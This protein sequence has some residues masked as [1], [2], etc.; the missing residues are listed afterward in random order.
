MTSSLIKNMKKTDYPLLAFAALIALSIRM[1]PALN[2]DFP[3]ND[4]GLF[5]AMISD[6]QAAHFSLPVFTT[7]NGADIPFAYPPLAFYLAGLLG[8]LFHISTL[9]LLRLLP[10]LISTFN[11]L[12][13]YLFARVIAPSKTQAMLSTLVFALLPRVFAW[14]IMGGGIT[15]SL[16]LFFS[17]LTLTSAYQFYSDRQTHR[18]WT[19]VL[20]GALTVL[21]HP[22][23]TFHTVLGALV[24]YLWKDR[25]LKGL[26]QSFAVLLGILI[27]TAPW[28]GM[29]ITRFGIDPFQ[30]AI[31]ASAQDSYNALEGLLLFFRFLFTNEAYLPIFASLGLIGMFAS[32]AHKQTLLPGWLF[33][34]HLVEPRGGELYMMLPLSLLVGYSLEKVIFPAL[35]NRIP[36]D[37]LSQEA[38]QVY[39]IFLQ[40][41]SIRYF[42]LFLL[43]YGMLSAYNT[44]MKIK[45]SLS[46]QPADLEAMNWVRENV[47][48]GSQFVILTGNL[49]LRD[50]ISEW[51]PVLT[52]QHSQATLFGYEW[53]NDGKFGQ[54]VAAYKDL[55]AC[56]N[57]NISCLEQWMKKNG[58]IQYIYVWYQPNMP[59]PTIAVALAHQPTTYQLVYQNAQVSIYLNLSNQ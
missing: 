23:A 58:D 50:A 27:L 15:R 45:N 3:L 35:S 33:I 43:V 47:L 38:K 53:V 57:Q 20:L 48:P 18:V 51:F 5:Y 31:A 26:L 14:H 17:L 42:L 41:K 1:I 37:M 16:G 10:P 22:E 11:V 21:S 13:F 46:L 12:A 30:A 49:P 25:S 44:G 40:N 55:Q 34:T 7:Y 32:L 4:G 36:S 6:L 28:W 9:D 56:R 24:F 52:A 54:R 29:V 59:P 8:Y 39:K 2:A 19:L